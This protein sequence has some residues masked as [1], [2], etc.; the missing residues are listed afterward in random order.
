VIDATCTGARISWG[1]ALVSFLETVRILDLDVGWLSSKATGEMQLSSELGGYARIRPGLQA[2][3]SRGLIRAIQAWRLEKIPAAEQERR[4]IAAEKARRREEEIRKAAELA[5][6]RRAAAAA[7]APETVDLTEEEEPK[8]LSYREL[9]IQEEAKRRMERM[10]VDCSAELELSDDE[11][12][13]TPG[14]SGLQQRPQ[15]PPPQPPSSPRP[16]PQPHQLLRPSLVMVLK[17]PPQSPQPPPPGVEASSAMDTE[18]G[19]AAMSPPPP[20]PPPPGAA[21]FTEV[22]KKKRKKGDTSG[23]VTPNEEET[24]RMT[25]RSSTMQPAALPES[26]YADCDLGTPEDD[27]GMEPPDPSMLDWTEEDPLDDPNFRDF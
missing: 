21:P 17:K 3:Q 23:D 26:M 7:L 1:L 22:K 10:R 19:A 2:K 24:R 13:P 25:R 15:P 14:P 5:E 9:C 16:Q 8:Q 12:E 18:Q 4:A 27:V 6:A 11:D 20:P